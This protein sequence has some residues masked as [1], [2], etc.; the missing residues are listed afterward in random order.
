ME[1]AQRGTGLA[2]RL[3]DTAEAHAAAQGA[4][5]LVLW[6]DTRFEEAQRFYG[7]RGYVRAGSIR[8]LDDVTRSLEF[9]YAK[10][11]RG[12]VVEALDA[13]AASA[14]RRL[15]EIVIACVAAGASVSF[16]PPLAQE[17]APGF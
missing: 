9:R 12:L 16:L 17:T 14:E 2:H 10:P 13:A 8:I 5:R 3:L 4:A 11:A 7:K 15:A 6:S 1:R